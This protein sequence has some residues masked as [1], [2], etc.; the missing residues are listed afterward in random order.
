VLGP[1]GE[2]LLLSKKFARLEEEV[3]IRLDEVLRDE[4]TRGRTLEELLGAVDQVSHTTVGESD[5]YRARS[6]LWSRL[7]PVH[8]RNIRGQNVNFELLLDKGDDRCLD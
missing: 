4:C 6:V 8:R 5:D 3:R 1:R 7:N 2:N